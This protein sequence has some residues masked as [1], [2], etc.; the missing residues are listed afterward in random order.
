MPL[1]FFFSYKRVSETAYQRKFFEDLSNEVRAL[2]ELD[3]KVQVGFFDQRINP[4]DEWEPRLAEALQDSKVLVCAYSPKYFESEYCG[5][6]WQVFRMRR[7]LHVRQR[8]AQGQAD[9]VPPTFIR[10]VLWL[11]LPENLD[12]EST[13]L[14]VFRGTAEEVGNR[15]GLRYV[16]Q[17]RASFR[18]LYTD[19]INQLARDIVETGKL[20]PHSLQRPS[21][22]RRR[23]RQPGRQV[24]DRSTCRSS[25]S[26]ATRRNSA[27]CASPR[28]TCSAA[29]PTGSRSIPC[30]PWRAPSSGLCHPCMTR[31]SSPKPPPGRNA[32]MPNALVSIG[33]SQR[34]RLAPKWAVHIRGLPANQASGK[35]SKP[36]RRATS[37]WRSCCDM[38]EECI[39]EVQ[40]IELWRRRHDW[41]PFNRHRLD[42]RWVFRVAAPARECVI[43]LLTDPWRGRGGL[44]PEE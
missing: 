34:K 39:V 20:D 13:R 19:Y 32:A 9:A 37:P 4:G 18:K 17:Q 28:L 40:V 31:A 5:K 29:G 27:G 1:D 26:R 22:N 30:G 21:R 44:R 43:D 15:E 41:R 16:L 14:Q 12:P 2:R 38:G 25:S 33:C 23:Q 10:P 8:R 24:P 3:K 6:E 35:E 11:P 36:L 7:D 42:R